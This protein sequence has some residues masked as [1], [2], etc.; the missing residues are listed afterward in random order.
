MFIMR[1]TIHWAAQQAKL[2]VLALLPHVPAIRAAAAVSGDKRSAEQAGHG[3]GD[4]A[5]STSVDTVPQLL[6][7]DHFMPGLSFEMRMANQEKTLSQW[8][9]ASVRENTLKATHCGKGT[10]HQTGHQGPR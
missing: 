7:K 9:A 6:G 4:E 10:K 1:W 5:E 2:A 3:G 8:I